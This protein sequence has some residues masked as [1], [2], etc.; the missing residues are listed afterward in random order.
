MNGK[1]SKRRPRLVTR[2]EYEQHWLS[3]FG[4]S[5]KIDPIKMNTRELV[6]AYK[7]DDILASIVKK[8]D[9]HGR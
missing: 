9:D 6:V 3:T 7:D 5:E 4:D 8:G 1:G 2:E